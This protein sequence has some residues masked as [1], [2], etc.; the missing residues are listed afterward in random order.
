MNQILRTNVFCV[1][2]KA[3]ESFLHLGH[4]TMLTEM[5]EP[6]VTIDL[7]WVLTPV[8]TVALAIVVSLPVGGNHYNTG[9]PV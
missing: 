3:A 1:I 4:I 8:V 7:R 5:T 2:V 9:C 6:T